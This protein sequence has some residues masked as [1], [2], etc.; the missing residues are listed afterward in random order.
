M[1]RNNLLMS[2]CLSVLVGLGTP[3]IGEAEARSCSG[4]GRSWDSHGSE[5]HR[6]RSPRKPRLKYRAGG[7]ETVPGYWACDGYEHYWVPP[8]E[9]WREGYYYYR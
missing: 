7:Y 8:R 3:V 1:R 2:S 6:H 9:V 5:G 4:G